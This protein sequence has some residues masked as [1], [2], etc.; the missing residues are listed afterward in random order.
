M[1]SAKNK[2]HAREL[3][4]REHSPI[5][6]SSHV[7]RVNFSSLT[8]CKSSEYVPTEEFAFIFTVIRRHFEVCVFFSYFFY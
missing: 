6:R 8:R 2:I 1:R 7:F 5:W 3:I 4:S